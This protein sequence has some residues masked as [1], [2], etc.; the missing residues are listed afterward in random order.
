MPCSS[1]RSMMANES[2]SV[3]CG[4][5]F[6]V[7]RQI[8]LTRSAVRP[9]R[10]YCMTSTLDL[11]QNGAMGDD[12]VAATAG[13]LRRAQHLMVLTGAG[14]STESG[15]PDFRGPNGVWTKNPEAE[16]TATLQYYVGDRAVRVRAW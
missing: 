7:P 1:A 4:P 8:R 16:K 15:I 12:A 2:G 9:S 6:I 14:I 11:R 13:V 10:V 5:K 3:V